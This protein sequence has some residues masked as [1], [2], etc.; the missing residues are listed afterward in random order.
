MT[1]RGTWDPWRDLNRLQDE[2][3]RL[4]TGS[5]GG[6]EVAFPSVNVWTND[7]GALLTADLAGVDPAAVDISVISESVTLRGKR[8]PDAVGDGNTAHRTERYHGSFARTVELPFR[9]DADKVEASYDRGVL[10]VVLPRADSERARKI[11]IT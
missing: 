9:I 7:D 11:K 4:F 5:R 8:E 6:C 1:H 2:L 3:N 10:K